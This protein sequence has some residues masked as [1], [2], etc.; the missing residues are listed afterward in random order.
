[1]VDSIT[2]SLTRIEQSGGKIVTPR[3]DIGQN[4][5]AFAVFSGSGSTRSRNGR[6]GSV[7]GHIA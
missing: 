4:M 2:E 5:G 6:F 1:M 7:S 3:T